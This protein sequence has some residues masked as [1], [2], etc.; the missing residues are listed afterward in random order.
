MMWYNSTMDIM[1]FNVRQCRH[2]TEIKPI[3]EF[4]V[5]HLRKD[6]TPYY[7][8][9]CKKCGHLLVRFWKAANPEKAKEHKR[10]AV[11]RHTLKVRYGITPE[12]FDSLIKSQGGKCAI[13]RK[14]PKVRFVMDHNHKDDSPR[15]PLCTTC[16]MG[17]G[18]FQDDPELLRA[19][20]DY[21]EIHS[22]S[23]IRVP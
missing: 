4:Y 9:N 20:A 23:G 14:V 12:L 5:D 18:S 15:S 8:T 2:C 1:D 16:N 10:K 11:R 17:L 21:L 3:I 6:G 22:P 13:C 19:A 7:S